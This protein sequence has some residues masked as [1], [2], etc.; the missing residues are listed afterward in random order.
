MA[1]PIPLTLSGSD[2]A[3]NY[4]AALRAGRCCFGNVVSE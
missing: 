1:C 3:D 4:Q 2:T